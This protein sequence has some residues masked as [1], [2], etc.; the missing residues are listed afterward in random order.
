MNL[1]LRSSPCRPPT[2]SRPERGWARSVPPTPSAPACPWPGRCA[3]ARPCRGPHPLPSDSAPHPAERAC[4]GGWCAKPL[5]CRPAAPPSRCPTLPA[6][7]AAPGPAGDP[8]PRQG[9]EVLAPT[10]PS[11]GPPAGQGS[12]G[13]PLSDAEMNP[14]L[15]ANHSAPQGGRGWPRAALSGGHPSWGSARAPDPW[16][17]TTQHAACS[18]LCSGHSRLGPAPAPRA[19]APEPAC[20]WL[21]HCLP[22]PFCPGPSVSPTPAASTRPL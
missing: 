10:V 14:S 3:H 21:L 13:S 9:C 12:P 5:P 1:C 18:Q 19:S 4:L 7:P 8:G 2:S 22:S 20:P 17:P 16:G 6:A 15:G 11:A